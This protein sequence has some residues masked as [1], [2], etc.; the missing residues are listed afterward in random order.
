MN[1]HLHLPGAP[2]VGHRVRLYL[3]FATQSAFFV[4]ELVGGILTNSL[5]LLADAGHML[6]DVAAL[7]LSLLAMVY[8]QKPPTA[9]KTFGYH[10]LEILA[11]LVNGLVLWAM[12][13]YIFYE[14][15]SRF[16]QPPEL[17][18]A[19]V[20]IIAAVGLAVNVFGML[21]LYPAR[22]HN[23]NFRSAFLH[24][25]ADSLG[26]IGA[27]AAGVAIYLKGWYW[28]DPLA[29]GAIAVLVVIGSWQVVWEAA[30]ILMEATPRHLVLGEVRDTLLS[31]PAVQ[32]IHDLHVWSI[33][34]G[35]YSISVHVV[36]KD[37]GE[38]DCLTW[39]LEELL[40]R[41]HGLHHATIQL[42]GPGYH[43]PRI[44]TLGPEGRCPEGHK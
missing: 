36:I 2:L 21:I 13:A 34:S 5:A 27:L 10:R 1:H 39:E 17:A 42:E 31:H 19:P 18:G 23:L 6:S 44:C 22:H 3:A 41:R 12:A 9:R 16:S 29:G 37:G 28:F 30:D 24:L 33:S 40:A 38:R 8:A 20:M 32:E 11:A 43:N 14:A 25:A 4:V 26:S 7:G 15:Y 35:L